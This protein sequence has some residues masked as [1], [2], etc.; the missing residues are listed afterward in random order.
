MDCGTG[1]EI[2][3]KYGNKMPN[4][5]IPYPYYYPDDAVSSRH[6]TDFAEGLSLYGWNVLVFSGNRYHS[7]SGKIT[8]RYD[9]RNGVKI[10]RFWHPPFPNTKY[11]GRLLNS[12][13]LSIIWGFK[14]LFVKTDVVIFGTNPPFIYYMIPFLSFF[15]PKLHIAL[16]GFDLYPEAIIADGMKIP[17]ILKAI[18]LG[19]AGISYRSCG[20]LVDIGSCMRNRFLVYHPLAKYETIVPWAFQEPNMPEKPDQ[21]MRF[22]LFGDAKLAILYSGTIGKAHQFEEFIL[23]ARELRMRNASIAFCFAGRGSCYHE[24]QNMV[25]PDDSNITFAGFIEEDMLAIRLATA[26]IHMI[27][28]R[29]GWDGVSVPSKFFGSLA[30]GRPLLYTGTPYSCIPKLIKENGLGFVVEMGTIKSTADTLEELIYNPGKLH[31][32][33]ENAFIF[34]NKYFSKRLQWMKWDQSL[35][36]YIKLSKT[37]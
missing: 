16:W 33:Q 19:W 5:I 34:Y 31:Q 37:G 25:M 30:T 24:L 26:D 28:L 18:L 15:R 7:K 8:P 9:I 14:L 6:V 35:R 3:T 12:F 27:S 20:F 10:I 32:M 13:C 21:T 1:K 22:D 23:L 29:N 4:C 17:K 2:K 36:D 11:L